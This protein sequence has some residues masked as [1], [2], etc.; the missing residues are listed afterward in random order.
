MSV[1]IGRYRQ[2]KDKAAV[3]LNNNNNKIP[4]VIWEQAASPPLVADSLIAA[5]QNRSTVFAR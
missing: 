5:A 3:W 4:K 2:L 1:P